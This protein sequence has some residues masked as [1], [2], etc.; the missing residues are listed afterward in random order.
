MIMIILGYLLFRGGAG[1]GGV[2]GAAH[3]AP[4]P[5]LARAADCEGDRGGDPVDGRVAAD[6]CAQAKP[7]RQP[8]SR[9]RGAQQHA[10]RLHL[11]GK[12][13]TFFRSRL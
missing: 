9:G 13:E 1:G 8:E 2:G 12:C 5:A 10:A 4:V 11:S 7:I 3:V 6:I